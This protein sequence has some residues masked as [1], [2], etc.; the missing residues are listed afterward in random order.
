M[1]DSIVHATG[2]R[3]HRPI[4]DI[5]QPSEL[6]KHWFRNATRRGVPRTS[7]FFEFMLEKPHFMVL[8]NP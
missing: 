3:N 1:L 6:E 8:T 5:Q 7:D 4:K 2:F